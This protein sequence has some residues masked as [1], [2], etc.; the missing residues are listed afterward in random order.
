MNKYVLHQLAISLNKSCFEVMKGLLSQCSVIRKV[1]GWN[2]KFNSSKVPQYG[3][4]L[5]LLQTG[6]W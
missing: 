6:L 1:S 5:G 4:R 3:K 2:Q